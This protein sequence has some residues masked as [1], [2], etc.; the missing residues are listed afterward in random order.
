MIPQGFIQDLLARV[1]IVD[2]VSRAVQLKKGGQNFLG[3]CPFHSEKTPSFT[4]SPSKQFFHCF[5]CGAHGS[6]I[7][8]LMDH[9][10][11][12]FVDAVTELAQQVGLK[13]PESTAGG[14]GDFG[15]SRALTEA[16]EKA[17]DFYRR[18]LKSA[19]TAIDYLKGRGLTGATAQRFGLG[20]A[21]DGWQPL[22]ALFEHYEDQVLVDAGL[23]IVGDE[24]K[25]YD[26]FRGRVMFPIRNRR[27]AVI[28][29]GARVLDSGEPKYLNSPETPVFHKGAELYGLFE[30]MESIRRRQ[31]AIV[32]EGY[33]D[34]IQLAQAG[35]G[36]SVAALGTAITSHHVGTLLK[37]TDHVIF[38]FDGDAAGR[39]AAR[40]ALEATLPVIGDDK[41]A[42]FVL[43][44]QGEDPDSLIQ[45]HG[46]AAFEDELGRALPLSR[47]FIEALAESRDLT[48][49]EGR[50]ALSSEAG[51]LLQTMLPGSFRSQLTKELARATQ[52]QAETLEVQFRLQPWRRLPGSQPTRPGHE[53]APMPGLKQ[54]ILRKLWDFPE[55]AREFNASI[56]LLGGSEDVD[57]QI[58]EVWRI[59]TTSSGVTSGALLE[60]LAQSEFA[61]A[62]QA[63]AHSADI[64]DD[65]VAAA[66]EVL[67]GAFAQLHKAALNAR[68]DALAA[69][70]QAE[71]TPENKQALQDALRERSSLP[72]HKPAA[73]DF[74]A[75]TP[76]A[77]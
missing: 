1:D 68:I 56:A 52:E 11:L 53:P 4:V 22:R 45:T 39:K 17:A 40:R 62:Y 60:L 71:P 12:G 30:A 8:F 42:S 63:L 15:R 36:E 46:A 24:G 72:P 70:W 27:G 9:R 10:G 50:A 16:L 3:L 31:R 77:Q 49:A 58:A 76:S 41:R 38:A 73:G 5:G 35:F 20:Y 29:F 59:A 18:Q 44:P 57:R 74:T 7:A 51:P 28:A 23:V 19:P 47:W 34:V 75:V 64:A 66:R 25:R 61:D 55:L 14:S 33:M 13:V 26:R 69:R 2:V 48:L 54:Q 67:A 43:L 21:P 65:D 32:C 37:L 6:A